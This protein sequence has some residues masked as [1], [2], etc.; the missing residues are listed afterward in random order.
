[1]KS[2]EHLSVIPVLWLHKRS[3]R[4][5]HWTGATELTGWWEKCHPHSVRA[6]TVLT[7]GPA[8]PVCRSCKA[9]LLT[10]RQTERFGLL[11]LRESCVLL[12]FFFLAVLFLLL[13][14]GRDSVWCHTVPC[15]NRDL[16]ALESESDY[17]GRDVELNGQATATRSWWM[18]RLFVTCDQQTAPVSKYAEWSVTSWRILVDSY[19]WCV[20]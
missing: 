19:Y 9:Q 5:P 1:M 15:T 14:N 4:G 20:D 2:V 7:R 6:H 3:R 10:V 13:W 11:H 17:C 12:L 18:N 16:A 8:A